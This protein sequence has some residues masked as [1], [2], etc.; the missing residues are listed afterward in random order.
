MIQKLSVF[1]LALLT[2][3]IVYAN[4]ASSYTLSKSPI[5][6]MQQL[7]AEGQ[8][9]TSIEVGKNYLKT[10]PN[11]SDALF[12][13]GSIYLQQNNIKNAEFYLQKAVN[14]PRHDVQAEVSLFNLYLIKQ[15]LDKANQL[16]SQLKKNKSPNIS[17]RLLQK[18][19]ES[20]KQKND[21]TQFTNY[22]STVP[23]LVFPPL[24]VLPT[25]QNLRK[26]GQLN[27]SIQLGQNYLKTYP[28]DA[29]VLFLIGSMYLQQNN[30]QQAEIYLKKAASFP[31]HDPTIEV[32]LFNLYLAKHDFNKAQEL[33]KKLNHNPP[34][35]IDIHKLQ[36]NYQTTQFQQ[37][38]RILNT[39]IQQKQY[40]TAKQL[41]I[42]LIH[43]NPENIAFQKA[44][45]EIY[46]ET[47]QY[48]KANRLYTKILAKTPD[49]KGSL[50]A[51]VNLHL[52]Q[53][54]DRKA[55]VLVNKAL[56]FY[57]EDIEL[58]TLKGRVFQSRHQ[59]AVAAH[60]YQK[61]LSDSPSAIHAQTQL[62]EIEKLNPHLLYGLNET[63]IY[64]ETDYISDLKQLWQY[65]T[66]IYNRDT[67][68]GAYSLS[69]NNTTRFNTTANQGMINLYPIFN[70]DLYFRLTAAY[71]NEP[72]LF[73][74][75]TAGGEAFFFGWPAEL[76]AGYDYN[77]ILPNLDYV[78]YTLSISKEIKDY[79]V[80][81]RPYFFKTHDGKSSV[82]YTGTM[83]HYLGFKDTY[84]KL[85]AGSG[86]SPDL[87]N[88][89]TTNFIVIHNN[90]ITATL[91]FPIYQHALLMTVGA[92]FQHW[93]FDNLHRKR[94][95]S[96]GIIGLNYR[97]D[98]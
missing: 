66:A 90:F 14:S 7:R 62:N 4:I 41:A 75:Y 49:D 2:S 55:L 72:L 39:L 44:L 34:K 1:F 59:L 3:A 58:Q 51:L 47:Q 9:E 29:D 70:Q 28:N 69:I 93:I 87:A 17:I 78:R 91:Q 23:P 25:M 56:L 82:L 61:I 57:P 15:E 80:S 5:Q 68:W 54:N 24:N 37:Q 83:Y 21:A 18:N 8:L 77:Y 26:K 13:I 46:L 32:S 67:E 6:T 27:T 86:T 88:L 76:S 30:S 81:F 89:L 12:L 94:N 52:V 40:K 31:H 98:A 63:G 45:G 33:L 79:W 85:L 73:P 19:Y 36:F 50:T 53:K 96:G 43:Q 38:L 48:E 22:V 92:D 74:Q 20:A 97:F 35:D 16:L 11:D 95:I 60:H 64:N 10:Y 65:S 42:K 84:F 71:A